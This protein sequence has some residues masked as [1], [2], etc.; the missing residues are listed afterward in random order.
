[1]ELKQILLYN[2]MWCSGLPTIKQGERI[3]WLGI[4]QVKS[5]FQHLVSDFYKAIMYQKL[6]FPC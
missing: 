1:M 3:N 4:F 6:A 2:F 5:T